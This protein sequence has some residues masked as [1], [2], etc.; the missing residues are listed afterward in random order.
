M[1]KNP[2]NGECSFSI[3]LI[4]KLNRLIKSGCQD[5]GL[6]LTIA[7][8]TDPFIKD[9]SGERQSFVL[10]FCNEYKEIGHGK[11]TM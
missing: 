11:K 7:S 6:S 9:E 1:I 10:Q 3:Y 8:G 2:F 5:Q 4:N